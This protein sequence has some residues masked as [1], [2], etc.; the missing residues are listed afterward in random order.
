M[1][2]RAPRMCHTFT[3]FSRACLCRIYVGHIAKCVS[4]SKLAW[5]LKMFNRS[6]WILKK[7]PSKVIR[8]KKAVSLLLQEINEANLM[9]LINVFYFFLLSYYIIAFF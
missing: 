5:C 7:Y 6:R 8:L 4:D 2:L 3:G 9:K 1:Y